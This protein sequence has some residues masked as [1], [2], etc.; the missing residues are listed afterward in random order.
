[1]D[2]EDIHIVE[3]GEG[4]GI[5]ES[6]VEEQEISYFPGFGFADEDVVVG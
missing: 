6:V 1:M 3:N 4:F 5:D 2:L